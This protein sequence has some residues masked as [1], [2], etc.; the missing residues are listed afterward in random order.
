MRYQESDI[1]NSPTVQSDSA[2]FDRAR[3]ALFPLM[4]VQIQNENLI[5]YIRK[6]A[7]EIAA[8]S[9]ELE[10]V[11]RQLADALREIA[12]AQIAT[13]VRHE[14]NNPLTSILGQTQLLLLRRESLSDDVAKRLETI[15]QLSMRIRDIVKKLEVIK[16]TES[17]AGQ[18]V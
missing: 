18:P 5:E 11:R 15:E 3:E 1:L 12:T 8:K 2:A 10:S 4:G 7:E 13:T 6:Q 17:T 9:R 14:I 16:Q